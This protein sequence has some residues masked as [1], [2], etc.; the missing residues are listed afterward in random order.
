MDR[1]HKEKDKYT[2]ARRQLAREQKYFLERSKLQKR[3]DILKWIALALGVLLVLDLWVLPEQYKR[4]SD[5][6]AWSWVLGLVTLAAI[7]LVPALKVLDRP[8]IFKRWTFWLALL[9]T[10]LVVFVIARFRWL[11]RP[12]GILLVVVAGLVLFQWFLNRLNRLT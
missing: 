4:V 3:L 12:H 9:S 8:S 6:W 2:N 10:V 11:H 1:R 7:L 5:E